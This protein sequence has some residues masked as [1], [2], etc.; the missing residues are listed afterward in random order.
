MRA[1]QPAADNPA[2]GIE[3]AQHKEQPQPS[4]CREKQRLDYL[5]LGASLYVPATRDDLTAVG[6]REK[7]PHLRS[8]IF[9]LEDSC[10]EE[11]LPKA[12]KNLAEALHQLERRDGILRFVRVRNLEV[13]EHCLTMSDIDKL[14]GFVFPKVRLENCANYLK[15]SQAF[16]KNMITLETDEVFNAEAMTALCRQLLPYRDTIL[17]LRIGG[18]DLMS[19]LGVRRDPEAT[20]Y[21]GP[22]R[23]TISV[24]VSIFKPAGFNL[25]APVCEII[26]NTHTLER[27][28]PQDLHHALFGKTIIHPSHIGVVEQF[29]QVY[30]EE[31][32]SAEKILA[33]DAPAVFQDDGRMCEKAT[34]SSW[35]ELILLRAKI[36]GIRGVTSR[37]KTKNRS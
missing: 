10:C 19:L 2:D 17:S 32:I 22:L 1:V 16:S 20:I 13:L 7:Y 36:Y 25:T 23:Y 26:G 31:L 14:D 30:E 35:A 12:L 15:K 11:D 37:K 8:A 5:R 4:P 6:N 24:L 9:C 33:E 34:H 28:V 21:D 3:Q 29:Y 27:E 18:N